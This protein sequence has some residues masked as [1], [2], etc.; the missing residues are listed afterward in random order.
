MYLKSLKGCK[1]AIGS[2]PQ[3]QYDA[4]NGGGKASII[5]S[6]KDNIKYLIF[7]SSKF[8]IPPLTWRTTKIL[9]IS[10]PP[11]IKIEMQMKKLEGT[12]NELSGDEY[13]DFDA[14]FF[15][16]IWTFF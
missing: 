12:L 10:I 11:V 14:R 1:L 8:V 6:E 15:L 16:K 5:C 2:Y 13:L 3:F 9:G 4:T 7:D